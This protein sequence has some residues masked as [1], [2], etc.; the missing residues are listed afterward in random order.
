MEIGYRGIGKIIAFLVRKLS[1]KGDSKESKRGFYRAV[2][3]S[4]VKVRAKIQKLA[5]PW[6][7]SFL[8]NGAFLTA[9]PGLLLQI[10]AKTKQR[11]TSLFER[12][13][14]EQEGGT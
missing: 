11:I 2:L 10:T 6:R 14:V 4:A 7:C 13:W 12:K 5:S 1:R 8:K 9:K 3:S